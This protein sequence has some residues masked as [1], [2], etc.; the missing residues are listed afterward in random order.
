M[1]FTADFGSGIER[2]GVYV[3]GLNE[4][5]R[6]VVELWKLDRPHPALAVD[7]NPNDTLAAE[8]EEAESLKDGDVDLLA[9]YNLERRSAEKAVVID[10]PTGAVEKCMPRSGECCEVGHGRTGGER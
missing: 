10:I 8:A 5:D 3:P 7:G 4:N 1:G 2:A 9:G 6:F